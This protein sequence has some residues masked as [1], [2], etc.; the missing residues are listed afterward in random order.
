MRDPDDQALKDRLGALAAAVPLRSSRRLVPTMRSTQRAP[1]VGAGVLVVVALSIVVVL[2]GALG[3]GAK[4]PGGGPQVATAENGPYRLTIRTDA[5]R[6]DVNA[7]ISASATFEYLGPSEQTEIGASLS[8]MGFG[9]EEVDGPRHAGPA[10]RTVLKPYAFQRGVPVT[11]P[12]EKSGGYGGNTPNDAFV[13]AYLHVVDGRSDPILRLPGGR[14]RI[15][16]EASGVALRA[17]VTVDVM[18][19]QGASSETPASLTVLPEV[20]LDPAVPPEELPGPCQSHVTV[21]DRVGLPLESEVGLFDTILIGRVR[22]VGAAQWNTS[23]G[24]APRLGNAEPSDVMRLVRIHWTS[25]FGQ[26]LPSVTTAWVP[27]GTIGCHKFVYG[28]IPELIPNGDE[29]AF[30]I[31]SRRPSSGAPDVPSVGEMWR[32]VSG[33]VMSPSDE[34]IEV[35]TFLER[36]A[37]GLA[38]SPGESIAPS[39]VPPPSPTPAGSS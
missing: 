18:G 10:Y 29:F 8:F 39:S 33:S 12:F 28:D 4:S 35:P 14:W 5:G 11:Y 27:G 20:A 16:A 37:L 13:E 7:A 22:G 3:G 1:W 24:A 36:V 25:L 34:P 38:G 21:V 26:E 2:A 19:A 30:F 15:F 9:V 6:Y 17:A 23:T 31:T 32:V